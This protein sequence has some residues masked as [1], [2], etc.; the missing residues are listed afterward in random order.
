MSY[1]KILCVPKKMTLI[2]LKIIFAYESLNDNAKSEKYLKMMKVLCDKYHI[3]D[4]KADVAF[5]FGKMNMKTRLFKLAENNFNDS[6]IM[7]KKVK[8]SER[9]QMAEFYAAL[10]KGK[11]EN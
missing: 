4:H 3:T 5:I 1:A 9:M 7:Y 6:A 2:C 10:S 8:K 11:K